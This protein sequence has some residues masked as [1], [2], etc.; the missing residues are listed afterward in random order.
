MVEPGIFAFHLALHLLKEVPSLRTYRQ[1]PLLLALLLWMLTLPSAGWA[2]SSAMTMEGGVANEYDYQ[3]Y[4]YLTGKPVLFRG[5]FKVTVTP[6]G[7]TNTT[8]LTYTLLDESGKN[9]LSR[10]STYLEKVAEREDKSQSVRTS[11]LDKFSETITIDG[12]KY[13]LVDGRINKS[14]LY[15]KHPVVNYYSGNWEGRKIYTVNKDQGRL[16]VDI[17]GTTV[18]YDHNWGRTETQR[19]TQLLTYTPGIAPNTTTT[20]AAAANSA[21]TAHLQTSWEGQVDTTINLSTDRTVSYAPNEPEEISFFGGYVLSERGS[22]AGNAEYDLPYLATTTT[23]TTTG[24]RTTTTTNTVLNNLVRNHGNLAMSYTT[25]PKVQ[26][27]YVP[28]Y[29]DIR[30]HW[31]E[32][33]IHQTAGLKAWGAP[34]G[35]F[36]PAQPITRLDFAMAF[37]R[38]LGVAAADGPAGNIAYTAGYPNLPEPGQTAAPKKPVTIT[39]NYNGATGT[40][41]LKI[42]LPPPEPAADVPPKAP[43]YAEVKAAVTSQLMKGVSETRFDP[44]GLITR[45]QAATIL[46][47]GLGLKNLAPAGQF[48]LPYQDSSQISPWARESVYVAQRLGLMQGDDYG[49]FRPADPISRSEAAY[50]LTKMI[51][52]LQEDVKEGYRDRLMNL[53]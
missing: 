48:E 21:T 6:S 38:A 19:M 34:E 8:K 37:V 43:G 31:A 4:V 36:G 41:R 23:S 44:F 9:K 26:R 25:A 42:T 13:Q 20:A 28:S 10:N 12:V 40:A 53:Y 24:N 52:Y 39:A 2:E 33:S 27:L 51:T 14:V 7:D 30:G 3:E 22:M 46:V 1:I 16:T 18:G 49:L 15:D 32:E 11:Q 50:L 47:R 29:G 5:S 45:E 35:Y 17:S